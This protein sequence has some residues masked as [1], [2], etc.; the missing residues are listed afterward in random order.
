[1]SN[2]TLLKALSNIN[3]Q[4]LIDYEKAQEKRNQLNDNKSKERVVSMK[5]LSPI[6]AV[7]VI[8]GIVFMVNPKTET[9][10]V[11]EYKNTFTTESEE[12]IRLNINKIDNMM[13]ADMD[14]DER[15]LNGVMIPYFEYMSGLSIPDDFDNKE[16]YR[17]V[18]VRS[19]RDVNEYDVLNNYVFT[20]RNT[21]NNRKIIIAFSEEH[22]P[23]R[24]YYIESGEKTTTIGNTELIIL[25]LLIME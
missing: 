3:E 19:N 22:K 18:W 11:S 5:F 20:Y 9:P 12:K 21:S 8:A 24:D 13:M 2:I 4:Y 14:A 1:M 10:I 23:L 25:H 17:A 7:A 6:L 16:D 15:I